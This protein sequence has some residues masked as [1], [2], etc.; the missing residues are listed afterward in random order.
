[1]AKLILF[2]KPHGVL[3]QFS[4]KE[5]RPT[6]AHYIK[7]PDVYPAGRLDNDSEGLLLLTDDGKLQHQ[8]AHP[9][10]KSPK[11]YWVQ[12]EGAPTSDAVARLTHGVELNDGMTLPAQVRLIPTPELWER[13]T[14]IRERKNIPTQW[15]EIII[16]EGRNRQVRRMTAAVGHPTLR[17]VRVKI[18]NWSIA[19]IAPGKYIV[20]TID[21]PKG[22]ASEKNRKLI[23]HNRNNPHNVAGSLADNIGSKTAKPKDNTTHG[24][25]KNAEVKTKSK[26]LVPQKNKPR[27]PPK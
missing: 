9:M 18:G 4:D 19:D 8:I 10:H 21:S 26:T 13:S 14:P 6:L 3:S 27:L 22:S 2:N 11:T 16:S 23:R 7:I 5:E 1:M 25:A 24:R 12:V 17:L 15:L 20:E